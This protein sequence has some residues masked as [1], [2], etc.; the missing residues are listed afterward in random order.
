MRHIFSFLLI[1]S[2]IASSWAMPFADIDFGEHFTTASSYQQ[3][4]GESALA[5]GALS[6]GRYA[7]ICG[8]MLATQSCH[9]VPASQRIRCDHPEDNAIDVTS[10]GFLKN[11]GLGLVE[12]VVD[13]IKFIKDTVVWTLENL[14]KQ[15]RDAR[16]ES[17][18]VFYHSLQNYIA[19]EYHKALADAKDDALPKLA[20][21]KA[22]TG[23]VLSLAMEKITGAIEASYVNLGCYRP[24]VRTEKVCQAFGSL[25]VPPA[26]AVTL[27]MKGP[28]L[29]RRGL[30]RTPLKNMPGV[31]RPG[32][33]T[34]PALLTGS[35]LAS[36]RFLALGEKLRSGKI[37]PKRTHV[38]EFAQQ[39]SA[40]GDYYRAAI[41]AQN[42]GAERLKLLEA[43]MAEGAKRQAEGSVTYEW[44]ISYNHRLS[45]LATPAS[46]RT[47]LAGGA[48]DPFDVELLKSPNPFDPAEYERVRSR[49]LQKMKDDDFDYFNA[50]TA[51]EKFPK[52]VLLPT[53]ENNGELSLGFLND[54]QGHG[55]YPVGM[56]S[57]RG[58]VDG[59]EMYPDQFFRHDLVH[60]SNDDFVR[61]R[62]DRSRAEMVSF[63]QSYKAY[64]DTVPLSNDRR[65]AFEFGY[66][67]STHEV[68]FVADNILRGESANLLKRKD[69]V[70][71][72]TD[73]TWFQN[74][75]VIPAWARKD[76]AGAER[77]VRLM[78]EE[79]AKFGKQ[80]VKK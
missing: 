24:S 16:L 36:A 8:L 28:S 10:W 6:R 61:R 14:D 29:V 2:S 67:Y 15:K 9:T 19:I 66:F 3:L 44:W 48:D 56:A 73:P 43:L 18:G 23:R 4:C 57:Q 59:R 30:Q 5:S 33:A 65:A 78:D 41:L 12:S 13:F 31:A 76:R 11:C 25:V 35:R 74:E 58:V 79:L 60:A 39:V 55:V 32:E 46:K 21:A 50:A 47:A 63:A 49:V 53:V 34:L 70:E 42:E 68:G 26:A 7:E 62:L 75:A 77:F 38:P 80:L 22:V 17:A 54:V 69:L 45:L 40:H 27:M 72:I 52:L 51:A 71:S 64:R 1:V 20:A 37:D